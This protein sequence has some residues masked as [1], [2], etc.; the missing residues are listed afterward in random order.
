M[1]AIAQCDSLTGRIKSLTL[2][3]LNFEDE[4]FL[5]EMYRVY[6]SR[7]EDDYIA[8]TTGDGEEI[9][10]FAVPDIEEDKPQ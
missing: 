6:E 7:N 3:S 8:V 4:V 9:V 1:R 10:W 2:S 5:R